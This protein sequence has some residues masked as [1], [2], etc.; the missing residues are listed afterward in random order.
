MKEHDLEVYL[1]IESLG[2]RKNIFRNIFILK[3]VWIKVTGGGG[4]NMSE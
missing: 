2:H 3:G 1:R 4:L